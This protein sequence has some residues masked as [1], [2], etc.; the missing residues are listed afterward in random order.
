MNTVSKFNFSKSTMDVTCWDFPSSNQQA[1]NIFGNQK[2]NFPKTKDAVTF[3]GMLLLFFFL[4][5]Y[6]RCTNIMLVHIRILI[7][8]P[9][10]LLLSLK[11]LCNFILLSSQFI[12]PIFPCSHSRLSS[13]NNGR[14]SYH[15]KQNLESFFFKF[16]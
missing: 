8:N 5:A 7:L 1:S 11:P 12:Q 16:C 14:Q 10:M 13:G 9:F 3:S 15:Q 4:M 6:V 2:S